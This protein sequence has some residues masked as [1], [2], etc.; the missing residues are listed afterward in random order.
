MSRMTPVDIR[1][2]ARSMMDLDSTDLPDGILNLYMRDGYQHIINLER[3][4][5]FLEYS[6]D[7]T[8]TAGQ[9]AYDL[10]TITSQPLREIIGMVE[11]DDIGVRL[12]MIPYDEAESIYIGAIDT[13]SRPLY[14]SVWENKIHLFPKPE[15]NY[16]IQVRAYRDP[17]DWVTGN[18]YVDASDSLHFPI[19]YYVVSRAYQSQENTPMAQIYKQSFDETVFAA[20]KDLT[21]PDSAFPL[22]LSGGATRG[23]SAKGWMQSLGRNLGQ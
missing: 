20:R 6:F 7:F 10:D 18:T 12:E 4:W 5:R 8:A 14:Y 17:I 22:V 23:R 3:R 19:V 1:N 15:K 16:T 13:P 21:R 2:A 9:R 11:N